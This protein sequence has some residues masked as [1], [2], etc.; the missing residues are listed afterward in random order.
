MS[1][2][3]VVSIPQAALW[4]LR[5]AAHPDICVQLAV[6]PV[7]FAGWYAS[8]GDLL[9]WPED[10][11]RIQRA[12]RERKLSLERM[13][14]LLAQMN[15]TF[16]GS[17][18]AEHARRVI[19]GYDVHEWVRAHRTVF[20]EQAQKLA[21]Q[22][23]APV[24]R[25]AVER[26]LLSSFEQR[27]AQLADALQMSALEKSILTF[28]FMAAASD[29]VR[30]VFEHLA[31]DRWVAERLWV[32]IFDTT[33]EELAEAL[34]STSRL[35]L[36]GLLQPAGHDA[37]LASVSPFWVELLA[38]ADDLVAAVLEPFPVKTGAGM[39]ARLHEDDARLAV[40]VLKNARE[41]GVNLLLY[42]AS[43]LDKR[44]LVEQLATQAGRMPWRVRKADEVRH[45]DAATL[46]YVAL[47]LLAKH[48]PWGVL[49]IERPHDVLRTLPSEFVRALF[50]IAPA[51][52][53][54][55]PFDE[56]LLSTNP[57][58]ALWL[59]SDVSDL[60]S[61]A[62][63]RFVFHAPLKKADKKERLALLRERL[64]GLR[65]SKRAT[66]DILKLE[67]VSMA[68]LDAAVRAA[69]LSGAHTKTERDAAIVQAVRRSQRALGRDLRAKMKPS[70]T[71]Y[72]LK[73][74]N[75]SG[76]FGPTHILDC[77]RRNAR[78]SM[79]LYGPPGTGKTQFV[80]Y[81]AAELGMPLVAKRASDLL[82][83]WVGESEKNIAA[84]FEEAAME[85]AVLL[86]DEGDSFL[87]D[88]THARASWE[89]T[90]VNELLQHI[91]R[92]DGI[93]V[94]C[95]NLFHGLDVAALR[96][97]TFKVEFRPLDADQRWEMFVNETGL[98]GRLGEVPRATR[99]A[100]F[101]R[102]VLM[103]QLTPGD[104]ATVKRQCSLLG[105]QLTPEEWLTQLQLECDVKARP[106]HE[107]EPL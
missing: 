48:D 97:F 60:S 105:T 75:T 67:G 93:V 66:E 2:S 38:R 61:E 63:A 14:K 59:A 58:P 47:W 86:L 41:P 35:R 106:E 72:S 74:L 36:S 84:A 1:H 12:A 57:V 7:A 30:R 42:G 40:N 64:A 33:R 70:V 87:R 71:E 85:D 44:R 99:E 79:V 54:I 68:Q 24:S 82:S 65:L 11:E 27:I 20:R 16:S 104:F 76:R 78:G 22:L 19:E 26:G 103:P 5:L 69:K 101:E 51:D 45:R 31:S 94:V 107:R 56:H 50:G 89:V 13:M 25:T 39:P 34:K 21:N 83:K 77:L 53:E 55:P 4:L 90:Q 29:E 3:T 81:M 88:R 23:S 9:A 28:A 98:K 8:A 80:E 91:E 62:V 73:Y 95:T 96:R 10:V 102:L 46:T 17:T 43:G 52:E 18:T 32:A 92:F 15:Y 100:W 49:I 37:Q 6:D